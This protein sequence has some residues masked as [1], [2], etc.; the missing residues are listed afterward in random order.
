MHRVLVV[1]SWFDLVHLLFFCVCEDI[2]RTNAASF[3]IVALL[4]RVPSA[5]MSLSGRL[6][7][8]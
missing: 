5:F 7:F 4:T 6:T 1:S 2:D 3:E 8:A